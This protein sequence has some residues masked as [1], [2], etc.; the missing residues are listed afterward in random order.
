MPSLRSLG[1]RKAESCT[2]SH[3]AKS[4]PSKRPP[5]SE[6]KGLSGEF[7]NLFPREFQIN[8]FRSFVG[9]NQ[10]GTSH[11][12]KSRRKNVERLK[13]LNPPGKPRRRDSIIYELG[14][15]PPLERVGFRT[16]RKTYK[17]RYLDLSFSR[18]SKGNGPKGSR[19]GVR[20]EGKEDKSHDSMNR[21][22]SW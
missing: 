5:S 3:C 18:I 16:D 14:L 6:R 7:S 9:S 10:I 4:G 12:N 13:S 21:S 19:A 17:F 2:V 15:P 8:V 1:L 20:I 11:I 22:G